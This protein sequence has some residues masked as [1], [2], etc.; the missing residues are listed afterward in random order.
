MGTLHKTQKSKLTMSIKSSVQDHIV[1]TFQREMQSFLM[2][3]HSFRLQRGYRRRLENLLSSCLSRVI[4]LAIYHKS[5]RVDFVVDR[6]PDISIRN[7]ERNKWASGGLAVINIYGAEQRLPAQWGKFLKY[8]RNKE[9]LIQFLFEQW[10]TYTSMMFSGIVVYVCHDEKCHRLEP[11]VDNEPN[12]IEEKQHYL[13]ITKKPTP[14]CFK[15]IMR[16]SRTVAL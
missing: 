15:Q 5:S 16:L 14:E 3:W 1:A 4:K 8:G 13:A 11:G 6:Y 7:L 9:A 2:G 12:T 10:C